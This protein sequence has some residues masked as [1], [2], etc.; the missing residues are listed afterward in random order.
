M[1]RPPRTLS[2]VS[3]FLLL[4]CG[5]PSFAEE[6]I[7]VQTSVSDYA[8]EWENCAFNREVV[9]AVESQ[10][11]S[12]FGKNLALDGLSHDTVLGPIAYL[13]DLADNQPFMV[14]KAQSESHPYT[15]VEA[16]ETHDPREAK[17]RITNGKEVAE[18]SYASSL[19]TQ[20]IAQPVAAPE[21]AP[22][23]RN[24]GT[25]A[26]AGG[27]RLDDSPSEPAA[28]S[29]DKDSGETNAAKGKSEKLKR[30]LLP[31]RGQN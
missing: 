22:P 31:Q 30:I 9:K 4:L 3:S 14:T 17:V 1:V 29:G 8:V 11:S 23:G 16:N 20:K 24:G 28:D 27:G 21:T 18:V 7:P 12:T 13:R 26:S 5:I 6:T 19:M 15:I 25:G 2:R 10:I